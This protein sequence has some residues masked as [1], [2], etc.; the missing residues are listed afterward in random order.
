[1]RHDERWSLKFRTRSLTLGTQVS[2]VG[3]S[4]TRDLSDWGYGDD[5]YS[6]SGEFRSNILVKNHFGIQSLKMRG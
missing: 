3:F 2:V 1:M 4:I 5:R 6:D